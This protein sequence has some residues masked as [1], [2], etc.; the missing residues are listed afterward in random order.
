MVSQ[1]FL[2]WS[3]IS[4]LIQNNEGLYLDSR[5][6][7]EQL[8][9]TALQDTVLSEDEHSFLSNVLSDLES[10]ENT[11]SRALEDGIIDANEKA[12]LFTLRMRLI[13]KMYDIANSDN[14]ITDEETELIRTTQHIINS[15][16]DM[17]RSSKKDY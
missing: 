13:Q 12:N 9:K 11:V 7:W 5:E 17:E 3:S 1:I 8:I 10:Y 2:W 16:A 4:N 14:K 6:I 15:L